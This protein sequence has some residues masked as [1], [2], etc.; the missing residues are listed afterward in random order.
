[1]TGSCFIAERRGAR[2]E[3]ISG[4]HVDMLLSSDD[5]DGAHMDKLLSHGTHVDMLL[6]PDDQ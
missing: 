1:M 2:G 3:K 5:P 6:S 4:A